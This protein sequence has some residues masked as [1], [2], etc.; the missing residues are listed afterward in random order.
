MLF[1]EAGLFEQHQFRK[2]VDT[3]YSCACMKSEIIAVNVL[4]LLAEVVC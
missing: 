1:Y 2:L 3:K 4:A